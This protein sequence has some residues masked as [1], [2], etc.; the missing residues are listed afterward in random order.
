MKKVTCKQCG[1]EYEVDNTGEPCPI[2]NCANKSTELDKV[3]RLEQ[4]ILNNI[5][6]GFKEFGIEYT[7]ELL[8]KEQ[9]GYPKAVYR[10]VIRK[11]F[12]GL[13]LCFK[14]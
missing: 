7:L 3:D 12:R 9:S 14:K 2:C 11:Y 6:L 4:A 1:Y 10:D 13:E 5:L 8:D